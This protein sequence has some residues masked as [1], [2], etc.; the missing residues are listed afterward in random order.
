MRKSTY[1]HAEK[2]VWT[3]ETDFSASWH[4]GWKV[5]DMI[6]TAGK[7]TKT[8]KQKSISRCREWGIVYI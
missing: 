3:H 6:K 5:P 7:M 4:Y 2:P 8:E 1:G